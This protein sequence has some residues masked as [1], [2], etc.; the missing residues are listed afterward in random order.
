MMH[1][2]LV[3]LI[4]LYITIVTVINATVTVTT[5]TITATTTTTTTAT[6]TTQTSSPC[7]VSPIS[8]KTFT[9]G[10][11][12]SSL[13]P[14]ELTYDGVIKGGLT[15]NSKENNIFSYFL[16]FTYEINL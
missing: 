7:S 15:Q 3:L 9:N 4:S 5:A 13:N 1:E 16:Y 14:T 12:L 6:T 10:K 2:V 8:S 11:F